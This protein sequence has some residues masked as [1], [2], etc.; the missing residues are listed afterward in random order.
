MN[1]GQTIGHGLPIGQQLLRGQ[2]STAGSLLG[3]ARQIGHAPSQA[4]L[5]P[6]HKYCDLPLFCLDRIAPDD[7]QCKDEG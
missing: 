1:I 6:T 3:Q 4:G 2:T 5:Q 7:P